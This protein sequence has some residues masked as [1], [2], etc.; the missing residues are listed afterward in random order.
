MPESVKISELTARTAVDTDLVPAVDSTF[1]Q[2]VR[3]SAASIAAIGGGPP[4]NNTV[5]TAKLVDGAVTYPKIQNVSATDRLLGRSSA[6]AGVIEEIP[7]T[8]FARQVLSTA[9]AGQLLTTI[10]ALASTADPTFTGAVKIPSGSASAPS[11]TR[12]GDLDTGLFFPAD[13]TVGIATDG[14]ERLR[15]ANNGA[16]SAPV[17]GGSTLLPLFGARAWVNFNGATLA[18]RASG[19]VTSITRLLTGKYQ[20]NLTTA[21][22]DTNYA[23]F[24]MA[25][26]ILTGNASYDAD[27]N[28]VQPAALDHDSAKSVS[29]FVCLSA[30]PLDTDP[31]GLFDSTEYNAMVWR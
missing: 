16:L 8:S 22:P 12:T 31:N 6:G 26:D 4:G 13:G 24:A 25:R 5:T 23:I 2:T 10:G 14:V 11:L 15:I 3:V 21:M 17:A 7:C 27:Y 20:V 19:N 9:S 1:T 29:S 28:A 30:N 18:I